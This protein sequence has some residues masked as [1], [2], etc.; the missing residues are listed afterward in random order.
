L[1]LCSA[2]TYIGYYRQTWATP[3]NTLPPGMNIGIAFNGWVDPTTAV[4]QSS[5]VFSSLPNPYISLGGGNDDGS[6]SVQSI[7]DVNNAIAAGTFSGYAGLCY[8]IEQGATGLADLF[9]Q[10]FAKAKGAGFKVLVTTSHSGPYGIGDAVTVMDQIFAS[11]NVDYVS[12]QLYTSGT[13]T[14]ND[15]TTSG[16]VPWSSWQNSKANILLSIPQATLWG[17]G[18]TYFTTTLG[19]PP[20]KIQGYIVWNNADPIGSSSCGGGSASSA[21]S[22]R[23]TRCG[24]SWSDANGRCGTLCAA[25]ADC[26]ND[27]GLCYA[28]LSAISGCSN[29]VVEETSATT[30]N[31]MGMS[32]TVI[33]LSAALVVLGLAL[34]VVSVFLYKQ[35]VVRR[36]E[37]A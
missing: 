4:Q 2:Q 23:T 17:C 22:P 26:S 7:A 24:S 33:G 21:S 12:P 5:P 15:Y 16:S 25:N 10:S 9:E 18:N 20:A 1:S 37:I 36:A 29:S 14:T 35:S 27:G 6:W 13:E 19:F 11:S 30:L 28:S 8:D 31:N 3:S 32:P 34:I